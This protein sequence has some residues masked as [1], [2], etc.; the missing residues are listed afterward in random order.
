MGRNNNRNVKVIHNARQKAEAAARKE[1][2]L[3][4]KEKMKAQELK[5]SNKDGDGEQDGQIKIEKD[6]E[7]EKQADQE[8]EDEA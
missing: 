6:D 3:N 4:F 1:T 2:L 5:E 7:E 8:E